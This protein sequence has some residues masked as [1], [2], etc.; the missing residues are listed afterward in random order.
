MSEIVKCPV[1][2]TKQPMDMRIDS[3][4]CGGF[5]A[6]C[7]CS[8]CGYRGMWSGARLDREEAK[9][10]AIERADKGVKKK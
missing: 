10:V 5:S 2:D 1:C 6:R 4:I 7:E 3:F 9:R 8:K